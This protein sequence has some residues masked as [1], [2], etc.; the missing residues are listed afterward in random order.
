MC[1]RQQVRAASISCAGGG[2]C[3]RERSERL[4]GGGGRGAGAAEGCCRPLQ[5]GAPC[6]RAPGP[7]G[8]AWPR[9]GAGPVRDC[10]GALSGEGSCRFTPLSG[11]S[12]AR[13]GRGWGGAGSCDRPSAD[14]SE[15]STAR[16]RSGPQPPRSD[17]QGGLKS[18]IA[19]GTGW[20]EAR[21]R[22]HGGWPEGAVDGGAEV[23]ELFGIGVREQHLCGLARRRQQCDAGCGCR[24]FCAAA[25][26]RRR[27]E[28]GQG[29]VGGPREA[30]GQTW[31]RS[32]LLRSQKRTVR[33]PWER[34]S[35]KTPMLPRSG[36]RSCGRGARELPVQTDG[37]NEGQCA[38]QRS[39]GNA[40]SV[41]RGSFAPL[42][43]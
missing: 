3:A 9:C 19:E 13:C 12:T 22:H 14:D 26:G 6:W 24:W 35:L 5:D 21:G 20:A 30:D 11:A 37:G 15:V 16:L 40:L 31:A 10:V 29:V 43:A 2:P 7:P 33:R 32:L 17:M 4:G 18:R 1:H 36:I 34:R 25:A 28:A 27:E 39:R 8:A 42:L 41:L 38:R 23:P